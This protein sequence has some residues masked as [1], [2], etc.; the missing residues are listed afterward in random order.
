M[1]LALC[2]A[3]VALVVAGVWAAWGPPAALAVAGA[4]LILAGL[5]CVDV[6][7][8]PAPGSDGE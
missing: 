8:A 5:L 1:A 2:V 4:V 3:G 7:G 6:D